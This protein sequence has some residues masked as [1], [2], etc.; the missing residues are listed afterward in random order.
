MGKLDR[1]ETDFKT[2]SMITKSIISINIDQV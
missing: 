1:L 2:N